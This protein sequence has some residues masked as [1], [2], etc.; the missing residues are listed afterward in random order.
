MQY[1]LIVKHETFRISQA[2]HNSRKDKRKQNN[3]LK[4]LSANAEKKKEMADYANYRSR[5]ER[6]KSP[7]LLLTNM[8]KHSCHSN[9]K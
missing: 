3:K 9:K 2:H 5:R 1:G 4:E 6:G 8:H 7:A